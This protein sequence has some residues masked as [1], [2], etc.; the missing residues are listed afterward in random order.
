MHESTN[1]AK[2]S[3]TRVVLPLLLLL[4]LAFAGLAIL[5]P[6]IV[7]KK[8]IEAAAAQ[9]VALSIG[10][11]AILPGRARLKNVTATVL[12]RSDAKGSPKASASATLVD[13][14][15]DWLTPTAID[16]SGAK[17]A[18][19]ADVVDLRAAFASRSAPGGDAATLTRVGVHDGSIE[20]KRALPFDGL[21]LEADH[22][23]AE[24]AKKPTRAL[25]DDYRVE[26]PELHATAKKDLAAWHALLDADDVGSRVEIAR[27]D[28]ATIKLA[29]TAS[30]S[31]FDVD[32]KSTSIEELG[33]PP[34]VLGFHGDETSRFEIHLH[35]KTGGKGDT[36]G[37]QGTLVATATAVFLG[38]SIARTTFAVDVSY[39]GD[40][41]SVKITSGTLRAGPF[42]GPLEGSFSYD[43]TGMKASVRYASGVMACA[44]AVKAQ[45]AELGRVGQGA[46]ALAGMLGLDKAV[47]GR[48]SLH[49]EIEIDT[50]ANVSR[51]SFHTQG[52]CKLSYLPSYVPGGL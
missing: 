49:G 46:V 16:V 8:I 19:D 20:W 42:S 27:G 35:H 36:P 22:V 9:G 12:I 4:A 26:I 47:D 10:D 43:D 17:I 45:V 13:V 25:G 31:A 52:D 23:N 2:R 41:Q 29:R 11:L 40:P 30:S 18:L 33:L 7:K 3:I 38:A 44:D 39:L 51:A 48:V 21:V 5:L 37:A 28:V 6:R 1:V 24:I 15:L 32:T 34:D 50:R 14:T